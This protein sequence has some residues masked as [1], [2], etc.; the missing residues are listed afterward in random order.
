MRLF[1]PLLALACLCLSSLAQA[2]IDPGLL[3]PLTGDDPDARIAAVSGIAALATPEAMNLLQ[4]LQA[5]TLYATPD[6]KLFI[7]DGEQAEDAATGHK[8]AMPDGIDGLM[9]NNRL[10]AAVEGALSGLKLLAPDRTQ[11]L[12]AAQELQQAVD[13]AQIPLI[14]KA[15]G[16]ESDADIRQILQ[17][18]IASANLHAPDAATRKLA[19]Q[20]LAGD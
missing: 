17:V 19:V 13:P 11:R 20:A 15:L 14:R 2:A 6:G 8:V 7:V 10:R 3:K 18:L 12:A 16:Q 5:E 1:S 9:V 4:A